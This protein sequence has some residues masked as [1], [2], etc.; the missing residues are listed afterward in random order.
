MR[1]YTWVVLEE[2]KSGGIAGT[3]LGLREVG[4]LQAAEPADPTAPRGG[5][6]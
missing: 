2:V 4:A 6:R 5:P 3:A 1:A